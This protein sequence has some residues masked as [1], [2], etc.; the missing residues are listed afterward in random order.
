MR[1]GENR[2]SS[3]LVADGDIEDGARRRV[4]AAQARLGLLERLAGVALIA[5][6]GVASAIVGLRVR[7]GAISDRIPIRARKGACR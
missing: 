3:L 5:P 1:F 7:E 6:G 4:V 2:L